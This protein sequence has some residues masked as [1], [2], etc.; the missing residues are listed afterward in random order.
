M[1]KKKRRDKIEKE[2]RKMVKE[3]LIAYRCYSSD[4][5]TLVTKVSAFRYGV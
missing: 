1:D 5:N 2:F 4:T 3:Q